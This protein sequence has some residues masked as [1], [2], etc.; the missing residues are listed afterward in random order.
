MCLTLVDVTVQVLP[1]AKDHVLEME[2][3]YGIRVQPHELFL[4]N[5]LQQTEGIQN[6]FRTNGRAALQIGHQ[7]EYLES[8]RR[9][10]EAASIIIRCW[11][12]MESLTGQ[13]FSSG[14]TIQVNDEVR[15]LI[16]LANCRMDPL[17][18]RRRTVATH[19]CGFK[20]LCVLCFFK[21]TVDF[22]IS[23]LYVNFSISELY[24]MLEYL[25]TSGLRLDFWP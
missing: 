18:T 8:K 1:G 20:F 3:A 23:M 16:P 2:D 24:A 10:C 25:C 21:Y 7:L 11:W 19:N 13:E 4:R 5:C 17:F 15:G 22:Y 14:E 9:Q 12:L 6:Q